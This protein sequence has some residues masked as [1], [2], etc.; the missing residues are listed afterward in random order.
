MA[1]MAFD[2]PALSVKTAATVAPVQFTASS[3]QFTASSAQF[4]ASSVYSAAGSINSTVSPG[5]SSAVLRACLHPK[6]VNCKH[7]TVSVR[8]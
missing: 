6:D 7:D 8:K 2:D 3:A 1:R 4:T 5:N